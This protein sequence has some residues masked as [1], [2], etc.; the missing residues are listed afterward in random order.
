VTG[1]NFGVTGLNF[2]VTHPPKKNNHFMNM[3]GTKKHVE[4]KLGSIS[5]TAGN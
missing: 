5:A 2:G 4:Y 1:L 3:F